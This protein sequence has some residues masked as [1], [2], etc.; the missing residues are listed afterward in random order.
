MVEP[1]LLSTWTFG[2]RA[3]AAGWP[4]LTAAK[5][6]SL[7]AVEHACRASE[8]DPQVMSVGL[9]GYPDRSGE[10]TLDAA[11]MRSPSQCGSVCCVRRFMHPVSIARLVMEK[12]PHVLLAGDGADRFAKL[13]GMTP[14]DLLTNAAATTQRSARPA[15]TSWSSR[16]G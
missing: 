13:Q 15:A 12:T 3:N 14:A 7:D 2:Q 4:C 11:I 6:S 8:A 10:V 1:I 5:P 16:S 9:G